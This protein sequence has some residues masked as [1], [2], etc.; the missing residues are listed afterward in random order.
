M[1]KFDVRITPRKRYDD[2]EEQKY[3]LMVTH[4]GYQW[5]G[6]TLT[7][8]E[9]PALESHLHKFLTGLPNVSKV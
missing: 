4:N 9:A 2:E 3:E 7:V 6:M 1:S 5:S 8:N